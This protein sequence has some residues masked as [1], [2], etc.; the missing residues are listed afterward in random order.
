M[1]CR[2]NAIPRLLLLSYY[3][4]KIAPQRFLCEKSLSWLMSCWQGGRAGSG[5]SAFHPATPGPQSICLTECLTHH[6]IMSISVSF[7]AHGCYAHYAH[8]TELDTLWYLLASSLDRSENIV[9]R[10]IVWHRKLV[11]PPF[12]LLG[13]VVRARR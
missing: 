4:L 12:P 3:L 5:F 2:P 9:R 11:V 6:T 8:F 10:S 7:Y 1:E 13:Q